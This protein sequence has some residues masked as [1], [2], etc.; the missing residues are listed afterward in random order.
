[1]TLKSAALALIASA[2][3]AAAAQAAPASPAEVI[4]AERAFARDGLELGVKAAFLKHSAPE[5][6]ILAPDPTNAQAFYGGRPDGKGVKLEWWPEFAGIAASGDLGFTTGPYVVADGKAFGHYFTVWK[7]QADG[8]WKWIFDSGVDNAARAPNGPEA[9]VA[10]LPV[11]RGPGL[12]PE[13]ATSDVRAA[14]ARLAA[15]AASDVAAA[16]RP[17]LAADAHI[18]GSPAQ[19]AV[20]PAAFAAELATRPSK[21]QLSPIGAETSVAGDLVW[22]YGN[23][24]WSEA[25]LDRRGQ[26]VRIWQRRPEGWRIV[27]DEFLTVPPP[28]KS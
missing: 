24:K 5:A 19:P 26:Y 20:G 6:I 25:G 14:E 18:M 12:Y 23:A 17:F 4:A 16:Y 1:M 8:G 11:S 21:L 7:K 10:A 3:A 22:T 28:Q 9:P 27:F 15:A 2:L 13:H